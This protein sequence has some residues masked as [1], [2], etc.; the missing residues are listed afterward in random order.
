MKPRRRLH[1]DDPHCGIALAQIP[2]RAHERAAGAEAGHE[3]RHPAAGL[4]PDLRA[5][6]LVVRLPV[7]RIAVLVRIEVLPWVGIALGAAGEDRAVG[8]ERRVGQ[9]QFRAVGLQDP[10][11][12]GRGVARQE[13]PDRIAVGGTQHRV[14]DSR[15]AAG[16]IDDRLARPQIP[17]EGSG[18]DHV[19]GGSVLDGSSGIEVLSL[20]VDADGPGLRNAVQP[21]QRRVSDQ[22][23]DPHPV[24]GHRACTADRRHGERGRAATAPGAP[25]DGS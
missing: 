13:E 5:R 1:R 7:G 23:G 24:L 19:G 22:I 20:S 15:V 21:D 18:P 4:P 25:G 11:A 6:R 17:R 8:L 10:L 12:L 14:R 16:R 2:A 3:V 9:H